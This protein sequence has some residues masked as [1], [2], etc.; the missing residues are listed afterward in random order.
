MKEIDD[1]M[2]LD[3]IRFIPLTKGEIAVVDRWMHDALVA[4]GS[5]YSDCGYAVR[6]A[7]GRRTQYMHREVLILAGHDITGLEVDHWNGDPSD[8]RQCNLRPATP[9]Q[10]CANRRQHSRASEYQGVYQHKD[11][12]RWQAR[13]KLKGQGRSL[14][15]FATEEEAALAYDV[16]MLEFHGHWY[17][18]NFPL[19]LFYECGGPPIV[20]RP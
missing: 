5:W 9:R 17:K 2:S 15:C 20:K 4:M 14:G 1:L 6:R 19:K 11:T 3:L 7:G 18:P 12:G 10:N 13:Y 16:K 8:N